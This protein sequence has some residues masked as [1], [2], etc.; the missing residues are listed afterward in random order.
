MRLA[1]GR[2]IGLDAD[3]QL[4]CAHA[5]PDAAARLQRLGLLE[6]VE[7]E[8]AGEERPRVLLAAGGRRELNVVDPLSMG[9]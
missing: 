5:E 2:E 4:L 1:R 3:V 7:P 6:L 9:L 8:Q